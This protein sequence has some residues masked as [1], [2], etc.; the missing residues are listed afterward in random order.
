MLDAATPGACA[1]S[2]PRPFWSRVRAASRFRHRGSVESPWPPR[3]RSGEARAPGQILNPTEIVREGDLRDR[4]RR[5]WC[6]KVARYPFH[7]AADHRPRETRKRSAAARRR[8]A[9]HHG[10]GAQRRRRAHRLHEQWRPTLKLLTSPSPDRGDPAR[11][12][13][14]HWR[15]TSAA[16]LPPRRLV[17]A[18]IE[19]DGLPA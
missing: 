2:V 15:L 9:P 16:R 11:G 13:R 7:A 17:E 14:G 19:R 3:P 1:K 12:R 4:A 6:S 10:G 18:M 8:H 5:R